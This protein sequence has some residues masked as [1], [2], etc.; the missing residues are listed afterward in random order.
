MH[1]RT[2]VCRRA[3]ASKC[4]ELRFDRAKF[5][6]SKK[7]IPHMPDAKDY[8][9]SALLRNFGRMVIR[10]VKPVSHWW[11]KSW[12]FWRFLVPFVLSQGNLRRR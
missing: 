10:S 9:L 2:A 5:A 11:K 6:E 8:C 3:D 4:A 1:D 12:K 7:G